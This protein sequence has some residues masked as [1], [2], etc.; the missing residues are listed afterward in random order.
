MCHR[1]DD[2]GRAIDTEV[3]ECVVRDLEEVRCLATC[4][5]GYDFRT[6][7]RLQFVKHTTN[8]HATTAGYLK[9]ETLFVVDDP[10]EFRAKNRGPFELERMEVGD[11]AREFTQRN[12][13]EYEKLEEEGQEGKHEVRVVFANRK[14]FVE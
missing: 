13:F 1:R 3:K 10:E 2:R 8:R 9:L 5:L 12:G 6:G 7:L 14:K 11:N 4:R